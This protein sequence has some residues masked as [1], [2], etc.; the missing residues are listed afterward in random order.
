MMI[1]G[2]GEREKGKGEGGR[3]DFFWFSICFDFG[4]RV[5]RRGRGKG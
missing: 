4:G 3:K 5:Y 2:E 1:L